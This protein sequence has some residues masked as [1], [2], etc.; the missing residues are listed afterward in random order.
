MWAVGLDGVNFGL[1]VDFG[2][3]VGEFVESDGIPF[4]VCEFFVEFGEELELS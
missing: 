2:S 4:G 1:S 3:D